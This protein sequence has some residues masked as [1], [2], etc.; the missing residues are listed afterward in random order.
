M[1]WLRFSGCIALAASATAALAWAEVVHLPIGVTA[2]GS[3]IHATVE[4]AALDPT[5]E[6]PSILLVAG[7]DGQ[8]ESV[9]LAA[10]LMRSAATDAYTLSA[11]LN[12]F[13]DRDP[14]P[15]FPPSG[16]F[17]GPPSAESQYLWRFLGM[18]APGVVV[19]LRTDDSPGMLADVIESRCPAC[20]CR[21]HS[22]YNDADR[23]CGQII[24]SAAHGGLQSAGGSCGR[25]GDLGCQKGTARAA[26]PESLGS[27]VAT[28]GGLRS[29]S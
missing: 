4:E 20:R 3:P 23:A 29:R 28:G 17:Y 9:D 22:R 2:Q 7:L 6:L 25:L 16:P 26:L 27:G 10:A 24:G 8:D 15:E 13:P 12:V 18:I 14:V 5:A 11:V 19:D 21:P 1:G